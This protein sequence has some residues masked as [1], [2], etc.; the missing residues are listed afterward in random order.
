MGIKYFL[1][2]CLLA[3]SFNAAAQSHNFEIDGRSGQLNNPAKAILIYKLDGKRT[4]DTSD[5]K[6]GHFQFTG[7][8]NGPV[9]AVLAIAPY[10]KLD[11]DAQRTSFFLDKGKT[12]INSSEDLSDI[13]FHG[14]TAS[15][16]YNVYQTISRELYKADDSDTIKD[17]TPQRIALS[18]FISEHPRS[19]VSIRALTTLSYTARKKADFSEIA[20]LSKQLSPVIKNMADYKTFEKTFSIQ[21]S[22]AE[23][24]FAPVFS[25][26]DTSGHTISLTD[27]RGKYVLI[28]FWASWCIPCR[29]E[30]PNVV[31]AF[32]TYN[33]K[34]FTVLGVSWDTDKNS[35]LKAV[36]EDKLE[37]TQVSDLKADNVAMKL[38]NIQGIPSNYLIDPQGR[39]INRDL[40]GE[41]LIQVLKTLLQ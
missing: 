33:N 29:A 35:W 16:D 37:W 10:G 28:D 39:I 20:K 15:E 22:L 11:H 30:N 19:V 27:F 34:N 9:S 17:I 32:N 36:K 3:S 25:E 41:K 26:S 38:F 31:K 8:V 24:E 5:I 4:M 14:N 21:S 7:S 1:A 6:D 18:K 12:V 13:S 2:G 40:H 23:G